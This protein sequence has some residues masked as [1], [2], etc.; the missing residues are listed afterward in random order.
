MSVRLALCVLPLI[1][2]AALASTEVSLGSF[3]SIELRG[4][5]HVVLRHGAEQHVVLMKGSTQYTHFEIR[6]GNK[7]VI[8]ACT[9]DCPHHYDLEIAIT[10]PDI[11]GVAVEGGGDIDGEGA[12]PA[13]RSLG[14][15][16]NGGG[17]I[18]ARAMPADEVSAAVNGGGHIRTAPH[19]ALQAAVNGGGDVLFSGH[20]AVTSAI[21]G[22]GHVGQ[23]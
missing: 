11:E 2:S 4:G 23:D 10:A 15:A 8:S 12:F 16:V 5:G 20:P 19:Q 21:H 7:L 17:A 18:D 3:Q 6:D 13:R 9:P 1:C 14:L 22:G